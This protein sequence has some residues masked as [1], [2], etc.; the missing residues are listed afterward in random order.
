MP[1]EPKRDVEKAAD[2]IADAGGEVVGRTRLQ[3]IGYL[4]ELAGLGE[5]FSFEYR[6]YGPFS[7]DLA[8]A[9]ENAGLLGLLSVSE[10]VTNWGGHYSIFRLRR[11][12]AKRG[13]KARVELIARAAKADP[14]ELELAATAA[15]LA[16]NNDPWA[17]TAKRKPDKA[18]A[19][20]LKG[21]KQLY[22]E[23]LLIKTPKALPKI[24]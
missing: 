16:S 1:S 21:A 10:K 20:R 8:A 15:F 23:M 17:E 19:E 6:H 2:I 22:E 9:A 14:V 5:G 11:H 12:A 13:T 18:T 4:L 7:A 24:V 3:K